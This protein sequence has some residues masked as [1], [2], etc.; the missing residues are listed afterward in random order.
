[1]YQ[2]GERRSSVRSSNE[3]LV[4]ALAD[5]FLDLDADE[6]RLVAA[7][8]TALLRGQPISVDE[9]SAQTGWATH[10]L[11]EL[12]SSWPGVYLDGADR[13]VGF[14]GVAIQPMAHQVELDGARSWAWCAFDPLFVLPLVG[15]TGRVTS[16]CPVTGEYISL[17]VSPEGVA[18]VSPPG[19]VVSFL[20]PDRKFDADVQASFCHFVL[21]FASPDA[22]QRWTALHPGTFLLPVTEAA[23]VGRHTAAINFDHVSVSRG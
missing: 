11:T 17:T 7:I 19:A 13:L 21:F 3:A 2:C 12:L 4:N 23:A 9:L 6:Q 5:A 18:D 20:L 1:M 16:Q 8:Y 10:T 22:G 14:M 15:R